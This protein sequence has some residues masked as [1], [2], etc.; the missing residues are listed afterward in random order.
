MGDTKYC[1]RF[2]IQQLNK[3]VNYFCVLGI[4]IPYLTFFSIFSFY[5]KVFTTT[6]M[7]NSC[8][9]LGMF[10]G[11]VLIVLSIFLTAF[12]CFAA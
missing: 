8:I 12:R 5:P 6:L 2:N 1:T 7:A 9:S 10:L 4:C 3:K 11:F